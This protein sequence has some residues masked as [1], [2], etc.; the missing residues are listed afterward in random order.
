MMVRIRD[1]TPVDAQ[2]VTDI[3][4]RDQP[5]PLGVEK[6]RERL[7]APSNSSRNEWRLVAEADEGQV[8]GYGHALRDEW[9]EPGL[10]WTNIAVAHAARRYGVRYL[11]TNNDAENAPM[12]AVNRKLGYRPEP[13]CYRM[14]AHL[15]PSG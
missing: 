13:G 10:L 6:V 2:T 4:N 11:R 8:V 1:G 12:L 7:T 9:M 3:I 14:R 15:A 5:E